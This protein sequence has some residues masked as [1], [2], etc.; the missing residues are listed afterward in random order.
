MEC[1]K[2]TSKGQSAALEPS[3]QIIFTKKWVYYVL[4]FDENLNFVKRKA[5][6]NLIWDW[7]VHQCKN[8]LFYSNKKNKKNEKQNQI[9]N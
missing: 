2:N 4:G 6:E 7:F 1:R 8:K 5:I 3:E 9:I